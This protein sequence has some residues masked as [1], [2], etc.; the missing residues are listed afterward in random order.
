MR[1]RLG[2]NHPL[3]RTGFRSEFVLGAAGGFFR[4]ENVLASVG[5]ETVKPS[6]PVW[7][8][9]DSS[10]FGKD[11]SVAILRAGGKVYP[12]ESWQG[13]DTQESA[14]RIYRHWRIGAEE[15]TWHARAIAVDG[16]GVGSGVYDALRR[17]IA[18]CRVGQFVSAIEYIAGSAAPDN[19]RA[20]FGNLKTYAAQRAATAMECGTLSL[21]A[22]CPQLIEQLLSYGV[23]MDTAGRSR[24]VDPPGKS[25]DF[26]D[27]FIATFAAEVVG[28]TEITAGWVNF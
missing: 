7:L 13:S 22:G 24:I 9:V 8:G 16:V 5:R 1:K 26:G 14:E 15:G 19:A 2:E 28:R 17:K 27:A 21:P 20:V 10:R 12:P 23:A 25:P 4:P 6:E 11:L 18:E 3:Y